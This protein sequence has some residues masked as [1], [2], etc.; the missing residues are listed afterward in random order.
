MN[1]TVLIFYLLLFTIANGGCQASVKETIYIRVNQVGFLPT[2]FK[3]GVAFSRANLTAIDYNVFSVAE[4]KIIHKG[5]LDTSFG[6]W[7]NFNFNHRFDFSEVKSDGE[8]FIEINGNRS[9][10][11]SIS[12]NVYDGIVDSL[13]LFLKVQRC[14]PTNP[15]LRDECHLYDSPRLVGDPNFTGAVDVTGGWH[16]AGDY[17]KFLNTTAVTT[18]M[19]LFAYEYDNERFG[20]DNDNS[21]AP[22][23]LEEAKIGLDWMLRANY[24]NQAL[25][26]QVQDKRDHTVG[27]RLPSDDTLRFDRPAYVGMGKNLVGIF[28]AVMALGS[29]IWKEKF[30]DEAFS[31]QLLAAALNIY[32]IRNSV[33]NLDS[34]NSGMYQD[35]RFWGKLALGAVELYNRTKR[36][37]FLNDAIV[38]GDSAK[39][40]F[41]WSWGDINGLAHFRIAQHNRR[42]INYLEKNLIHFDE[43]MRQS[44]YGEGAAFSWGTT[45]TFLGIGLK[46][47]LFKKLTGSDRY[48]NLLASQRDYVLG[49]NPWGISFIYN[50]GENHTKNFHHQVAYFLNG[51]LPGGIAAGPAPK[52][53]LDN[54]NIERKNFIYNAFNS[55][56][57]IYYDDRSDYITNEPTIFTNATAIFLFG[58]LSKK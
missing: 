50:I 21:G 32:S 47:I 51:Y 28:S 54:Y 22:D 23:I 15:I 30:Y 57:V 36:K 6:V 33:P 44:I 43:N 40:D 35:S 55:D 27:W 42:F 13:L 4:N 26:N 19:L 53:I 49:K 29:K 52:K 20:F 1:K 8:Y 38:Y 41:W 45:T 7:G 24:Q 46:A 9:N 58:V 3:S 39:S 10:K 16:D 11:F 5:K 31:S 14:G 48:D 17:I 37:G 25:I 18:Y 12:Q 56:D 2:D 34:T